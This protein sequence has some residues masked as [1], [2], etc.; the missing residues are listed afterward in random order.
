MPKYYCS[1]MKFLLTGD[2]ADYVKLQIAA[3]GGQIT[4]K[5][6]REVTHIVIGNRSDT[7]L[8]EKTLFAPVKRL[9]ERDIDD[10]FHSL[11]NPPTNPH[12]RRITPQRIANR[13]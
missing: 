3:Y 4:Y 12:L 9:S 7:V 10:F 8:I 2:I 13:V 11:R 1:G 5:Y 6:D